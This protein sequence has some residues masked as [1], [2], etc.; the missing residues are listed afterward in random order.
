MLPRRTEPPSTWWALT[1]QPPTSLTQGSTHT[2]QHEAA[3]VYTHMHLPCRVSYDA[4][5]SA[6]L[7]SPEDN[8][9]YGSQLYP[10]LVMEGTM[11]QLSALLYAVEPG[12][13]VLFTVTGPLTHQGEIYTATSH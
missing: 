10:V 1:L 4:L 13:T 6:R 11:Y 5:Y 7:T 3:H 8:N 2:S 12:I 9:C